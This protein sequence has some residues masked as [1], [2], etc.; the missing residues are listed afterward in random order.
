MPSTTKSIQAT[1]ALKQTGLFNYVR[2]SK[3]SA[4]T[5]KPKPKIKTTLD[6]ENKVDTQTLTETCQRRNEIRV[7]ETG[8]KGHHQV[9][10]SN[11]TLRKPT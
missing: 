1:K 2:R 11:Q 10:L 4:P 8:K 9:L 7:R 3:V 6:Q 5:A